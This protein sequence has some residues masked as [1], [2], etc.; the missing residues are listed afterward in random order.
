MDSMLQKR[1]ASVV[2]ALTGLWVAVS[3][4]FIDMPDNATWNAVIGGGLLALIGVAQMF[5]RSGIPSLLGMLVAVW[6]GF[7][8][9][10]FDQSTAAMWSLGVAAAVGLVASV[11]DEV[12]AL[13]VGSSSQKASHSM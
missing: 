10:I 5:L 11:W 2:V 7:A 13:D 3:P 8:V 1:T 6:F 12:A 9:F 4:L